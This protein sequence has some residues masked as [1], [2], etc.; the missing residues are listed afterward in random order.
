M[1]KMLKIISKLIPSFCIFCGCKTNHSNQCCKQCEADLPW[2]IC[3]C[4]QCGAK[5]SANNNLICGNCLTTKHAFDE[6]IVLFRY[7]G[8]I[9]KIINALKFGGK[10]IYAEMLGNWISKSLLIHSSLEMPDLIIPVP[11]HKKR[12]SDRGFNQALEIAKYVSKK[13]NIKI[14]YT[15]CIRTK[16]TKAQAQLSECERLKNVKNAFSINKNLKAKHIA[17]LDDVITTGQTV[18][19][20]S[21]E[22]KKHGV[23]KITVIACAKTTI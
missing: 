5:L 23:E 16:N 6:T 3:A 18:E 4:R 12:L 17:I 2:V 13:L 22:L 19:E 14:N 11:L 10:L 7:E 15:D 9:P 21:L 1:V 8:T 20:L